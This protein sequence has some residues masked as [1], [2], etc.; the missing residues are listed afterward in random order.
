MKP[1]S[2]SMEATNMI[3]TILK[4]WNARYHSPVRDGDPGERFVAGHELIGRRAHPGG[5]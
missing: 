2:N 1:P 4:P 3:T 5:W